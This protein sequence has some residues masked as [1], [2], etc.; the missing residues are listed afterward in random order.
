[1]RLLLYFPG[2]QYIISTGKNR[3][4]R[5]Q[6]RRLPGRRRE[7]GM[8]ISALWGKLTAPDGWVAG[9]KSIALFLLAL[10]LGLGLAAINVF[11]APDVATRYAPMAEAFAA[12]E[13]NYAFHPRIPMLHQTLAGCF[14]WLFG[15]SGFAGC[16]LA[17]V[18]VFAL[19]VFPLYSLFRL[20][21]NER[22]AWI[23]TFL[24][25]ICAEL[26][27]IAG[28]G[29]RD[30]LKTLA[31][32]LV[33]LAL[34]VLCRNARRTAVYGL[35]ALGTAIGVTSRADLVVVLFLIWCAVGVWEIASRSFPWRTLAA[36]ML[37]LALMLPALLINWKMIG[38]PV[39]DSRYAALWQK[40]E[41][42]LNPPLAAPPA[43]V[44]AP[45]SGAE[46]AAESPLEALEVPGESGF[47][48]F[49]FGELCDYVKTFF[50]GFYVWFGVPALL[51]VIGR[52]RR[53]EFSREEGVIAAVVMGH[54]VLVAAQILVHDRYL[55][56][57]TR[58][59]TPVAPL[60]FGWSALF[61]I[62]AWEELKRWRPQWFTPAVLRGILAFLVLAFTGAAAGPVIKEHT[63]KKK[64]ALYR[65]NVE[66]AGWI[67]ADYRG[68]RYFEPELD[69]FEY[70][71]RK[72]PQVVVPRRFVQT[73]YLA[74]GSS[75]RFARDGGD[76]VLLEK[77]E[78]APAGGPW[79]MVREFRCYR[80]DYQLWKKRPGAGRE[81]ADL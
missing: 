23:G 13:W 19:C 14:C 46:P 76:Y 58:Y 20:V 77:G 22:V 4:N 55:F 66:L 18:L 73:G 72:L 62:R 54:A 12:G 81:G 45:A 51:A 57:S 17:A 25:V 34:V 28:E 64:S 24:Y 16:R 53:R 2:R 60:A 52:I 44:P 47:L 42:R 27:Q 38:Y 35:L 31:V 40:V 41:L 30:N 9:H 50:E 21:W 59:L 6:E 71:S 69:P 26:Q 15:I 36:A 32:A 79:D 67:A 29:L 5:E 3:G 70:F 78:P 8:T 56:L 74:G 49:S 39:P 11:P 37:A 1:M 68:P 48:P 33:A 63:S 10:A 80:H 7:W 43:A 75:C 65:G 61:G